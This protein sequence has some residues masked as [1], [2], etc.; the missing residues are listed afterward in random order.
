MMGQ[1]AILYNMQKASYTKVG[2]FGKTH[3]LAGGI[4]L[5][6]EDPYFEAVLEAEV[7]FAPV[8]GSPVPYFTEKRLLE[9]PL[10]IKLEDVD[11]KEAAKVLTGLDLL[12]PGE[13]VEKELSID[14]F[15]LLEGFLMTESEQGDIGLILAVEE[16][17]EQI[18]AMV[19]HKGREVLIPLNEAFLQSIDPEAERVE[20]RLPEGLLDL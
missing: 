9:E 11:T 19:R 8:D 2:R 7:L 16:Y 1:G 20:V 15:R 18:M 12:L 14:D 5:I 3:G 4:R 6:V 17:P 13:E 10:V